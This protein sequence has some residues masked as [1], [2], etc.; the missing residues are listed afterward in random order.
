VKKLTRSEI[1]TR[2]EESGW[3]LEHDAGSW[4]RYRHEAIKAS[5]SVYANAGHVSATGDLKTEI[6]RITGVMQ[7]ATDTR[8]N[9]QWKNAGAEHLLDA[10]KE[11]LGRKP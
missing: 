4:R 2:L 11:R 8:G 3:D 7:S 1:S 9:Y 6:V 5:G 10:L